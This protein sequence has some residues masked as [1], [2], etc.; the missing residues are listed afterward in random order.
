MKA[1]YEVK[2][3]D[4]KKGC[5]FLVICTPGFC[6]KFYSNADTEEQAIAEAKD[7]A[8]QATS[9]EVIDLRNL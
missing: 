3:I 1:K 8:W 4:L 2:G 5:N 6:E 9:F 7:I